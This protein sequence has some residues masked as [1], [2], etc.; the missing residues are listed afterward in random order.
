M[1]KKLTENSLIKRINKLI[2]EAKAVKLSEFYGDDSKG[3][4]F[5]GSEDHTPD[6]RRIFD[7]Y[8]EFGY[9]I[10]P[11]LEKILENSGWYAEPY[12]SGTLMAYED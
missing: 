9:M 8:E 12:D 3:I 10:H 6:Y 7:C 2:P 5:K 4:W 11:K 1:N